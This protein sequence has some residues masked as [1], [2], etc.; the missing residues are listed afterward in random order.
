M[1]EKLGKQTRMKQLYSIMEIP[2][3][4]KKDLKEEGKCIKKFLVHIKLKLA[5]QQVCRSYLY[6]K[7][8]VLV[9]DPDEQERVGLYV[10]R[11]FSKLKL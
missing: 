11:I 6:R 5:R 4:T 10:Q 2:L 8:L 9:F 3:P 7:L 1:W